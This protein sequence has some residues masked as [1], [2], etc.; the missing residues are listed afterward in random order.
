MS[1]DHANDTVPPT[2]V[3]LEA[4]RSANAQSVAVRRRTTRHWTILVVE[5]EMDMQVVP[6]LPQV[7]GSNSAH[8]VFMLSAVTFIDATALGSLVGMQRTAIRAGGCV[9]LVAPSSPVLRLL[10][11]TGTGRVFSTF[12]ELDH[13]LSAPVPTGPEQT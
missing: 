5:G 13:A 6:L 7:G 4:R 9:R 2:V 10:M 1:A 12:D 8:L 3:D 11:L